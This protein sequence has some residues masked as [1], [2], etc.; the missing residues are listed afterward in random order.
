MSTSFWNPSPREK[1][2]P[3]LLTRFYAYLF[4]QDETVVT[5]SVMRMTVQDA[6]NPFPYPLLSLAAQRS[7]VFY[8][9]R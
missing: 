9:L 1:Y 4:L 8:L 7:L 5:L 3:L 6:A 2:V